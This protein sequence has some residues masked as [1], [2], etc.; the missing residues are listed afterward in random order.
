METSVSSIAIADI[1]LAA[2]HTYVAQMAL[3]VAVSVWVVRLGQSVVEFR[4]Q[5]AQMVFSLQAVAANVFPVN[6]DTGAWE[7]CAPSVQPQRN[8]TQN[9]PSVYPVQSG[10][11]PGMELH[12]SV[13]IQLRTHWTTLRVSLP[14]MVCSR[15]TSATTRFHV[16]LGGRELVED[17]IS[18]REK[19]PI[20]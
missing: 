6:M 20:L 16:Q 2:E 1:I 10:S 8:P 14:M 3:F 9:A 15:L 17:A 11:S 7:D 19:E 12:V 18:V 13:A 5:C 4:V